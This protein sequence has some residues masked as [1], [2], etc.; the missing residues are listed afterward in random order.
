MR[1]LILISCAICVRV[2]TCAPTQPP[3][4]N[5]SMHHDLSSK[6]GS[7]NSELDLL[8]HEQLQTKQDLNQAKTET[9]RIQENL[10]TALG[11]LNMV[12]DRI[13]PSSFWKAPSFDVGLL[14]KVVEVKETFL[15]KI[16]SSPLSYQAPTQ[17]ST[18][19]EPTTQA[20]TTQEPTT[21]L[22]TTQEPTTQPPTTQEPTTQWPTTQEP[23]TQWPTT[24]EPTTQ[25]PTTQGP[26]TQWPTTQ[27]PTTQWPTTQG[28]T[29]QWPT[30]QGP[31]T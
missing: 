18:T 26:T 12:K 13:S 29:T 4:V 17:P 28:P 23:T 21:Q 30:T 25:P 19:Q 11:Y 7:I 16:D 15:V 6:I 9:R 3:G 8:R 14:Y 31:T 20:S 27:G 22:S 5:N 1:F 2:V 10:N 24:Q